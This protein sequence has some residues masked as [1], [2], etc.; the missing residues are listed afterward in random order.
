VVTD[1]YSSYSGVLEDFF[2]ENIVH[3][4]LPSA[5]EQAHSQR[6]IQ[7]THLQTGINKNTGY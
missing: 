7:K 5:P 3:Q 6:F 4:F 2:G 1:I